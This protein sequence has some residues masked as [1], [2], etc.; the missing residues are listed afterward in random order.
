MPATF[1]ELLIQEVVQHAIGVRPSTVL[2]VSNDRLWFA[3]NGRCLLAKFLQLW[4]PGVV[5]KEKWIE[6]GSFFGA[7]IASSC[8][9]T[10]KAELPFASKFVVWLL[11]TVAGAIILADMATGIL[12][13]RHH[14][15]NPDKIHS[16]CWATGFSVVSFGSES[17]RGNT[18][19]LVQVALV[20][21]TMLHWFDAHERDALQVHAH[22]NGPKPL[23]IHVNQQCLDSLKVSGTLPEHPKLMGPPE[24]PFD[25]GLIQLWKEFGILV[26]RLGQCH[27]THPDCL[28]ANKLQVAG[29]S[30][31]HCQLLP[32]NQAFGRQWRFLQLLHKEWPL[33]NPLFG[34][35]LTVFFCMR[36]G[37]HPSCLDIVS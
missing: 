24:A 5:T 26:P 29:S 19:N 37:S 10:F 11:W 25:V 21:H 22:C 2:L 3:S 15:S 16:K 9:Q 30:H 34:Q 17:S 32:G 7:W 33:F 20:L 13:C 31:Q 4:N 23:L 35:T 6:L 36:T 28:F 27:H 18:H 14:L 8:L 12:L 1:A